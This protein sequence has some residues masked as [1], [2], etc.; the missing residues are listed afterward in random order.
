MYLRIKSDSFLAN[1][2]L[3]FVLLA[4]TMRHNF[5]YVVIFSTILVGLYLIFHFFKN[6]NLSY[7]GEENKFL[8]STSNRKEKLLKTLIFFE[9][10]LF[11]FGLYLPLTEVTQFWFFSENTQIIF[12]LKYLFNNGE[13]FLAYLIL[14]F[15]VFGTYLKI[16]LKYF[17]I[18]DYNDLLQ[19]F[20]FFDIFVISLLVFSSKLS[21]FLDVEARIGTYFLVSALLISYIQIAVKKY[22]ILE[23]N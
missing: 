13:A 7:D 17:N 11:S 10:L 18:E 2:L 20:S 4:M 8:I 23:I 19:K 21:V 22:Y 5:I 9:L 3:I 6:L 14:L 16:L 12:V 1:A 15:G